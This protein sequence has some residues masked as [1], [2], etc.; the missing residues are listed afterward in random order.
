MALVYI[1]IGSNLGDRS[2]NILDALRLLG[3]HP[4]KILKASSLIETEPVGGPPQNKYLNGAASLETQ[5]SPEELLECLL[6]VERSLGRIRKEKNGP[7]TI[8][9]DI[10]LYN[11]MTVDL[12]HLK[13]PHPRMLDRDFVM[14]PLKEIAP[15]LS[16]EDIRDADHKIY[17][18]S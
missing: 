2:Q 5:L 18:P 17:Q 6:S 10:L 4:L 13:I 8:D 3:K 9:L 16:P 1:G 7:R 12:P 11:N 14:I 15:H